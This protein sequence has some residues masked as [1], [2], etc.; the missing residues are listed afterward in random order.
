MQKNT[1]YYF[2]TTA[3]LAEIRLI[4]GRFHAIFNDEGLGSYHNPDN[5]AEAM[6]RGSTFSNSSGVDLS[7]L[8]IP[9]DYRDW[10]SRSR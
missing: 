10:E 8:E 5:A 1:L 7:A 2:Q 3:G 9:A 6:S 4:D